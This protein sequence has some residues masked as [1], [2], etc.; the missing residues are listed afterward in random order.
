MIGEATQHIA[1]LSIAIHIPMAQ[2]LK[3]KRTILKSLKDKVRAKFNVSIAEV[4]GLDKWQTTTLA[5]AMIGTNNRRMNGCLDNILS[6]V[7]GFL[8]CDICDHIIEFY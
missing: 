2:S 4:D 7:D 8:G 3:Q 5:F 1:V 6:F